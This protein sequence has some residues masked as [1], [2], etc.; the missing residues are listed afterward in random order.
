MQLYRGIVV[1]NNSPDKDGRVRVRIYGLHGESN[2]NFESSNSS[3][4]PW[5][6][7][8]G[9]TSFG[10]VSGVGIS[11]VLRQGTWV[12]LFLDN[13]DPNKPIIIGT[14]TGKIGSEIKSDNFTDPSGI[15]PISSRKNFAGEDQTE[16]SRIGR[17]DYHPVADDGYPNTTVL[18]THS[19]HVVILSDSEIKIIHNS[20]S[21][22]IIDSSG[23][24]NIKSVNDVNWDIAGDLTI[25]TGGTHKVEN[26]G[27]HSVIAP[28]IDLN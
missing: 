12:W 28:R 17:S 22:I 27:N 21:N 13:D 1:D 7:V 4:L 20:G 18:E 15:Y 6:E 5:A 26:G 24:F 9:G 19:G 10:L 23:S 14:I 8:M 2:S 3:S 16:Q 25:K 11:N